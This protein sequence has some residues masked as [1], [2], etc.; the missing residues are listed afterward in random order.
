MDK[1]ASEMD[2]LMSISAE[3]NSDCAGQ[4]K[5]CQFDGLCIDVNKQILGYLLIVIITENPIKL[6][7]SNRD[8]VY[9]ADDRSKSLGT[10]RYFSY[11]LDIERIKMHK[12]NKSTI[13]FKGRTFV[14]MSFL[15]PCIL[16]IS[17]SI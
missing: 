11:L 13:Y 6:E 10:S 1:L 15:L 3:W 16:R 8:E 2:N 5:V 7:A 17:F 12:S 9:G 4:T 14:K